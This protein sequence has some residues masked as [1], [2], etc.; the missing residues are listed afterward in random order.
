MQLLLRMAPTCTQEWRYALTATSTAK[1]STLTDIDPEGHESSGT[2]TQATPTS[3]DETVSPV[4]P[5]RSDRLTRPLTR[6]SP[7]FF[8]TDSGELTNYNE[9]TRSEDF[10]DWQLI[11]ESEMNF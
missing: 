10:L 5:R 9:A 3:T 11:T 7:R 2:T 1:L 8:L 4:L 6:Y